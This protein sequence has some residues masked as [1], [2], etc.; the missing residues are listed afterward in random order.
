M[1]FSRTNPVTHETVDRAARLDNDKVSVAASGGQN[2]T[3][4]PQRNST[5]AGNSS[6][7]G[8]SKRFTRDGRGRPNVHQQNGYRKPAAPL[9]AEH[10]QTTS[11]E[12]PVSDAAGTTQQNSVGDSQ[13]SSSEIP[14]S[15]QDAPLPKRNHQRRSYAKDEPPPS[16]AA[17]PA[18]TIESTE[19]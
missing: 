18:P 12:Q 19:T 4:T 17:K 5:S 9:A 7:G 11:N 1:F 3:S 14:S 2:G 16:S 8:Q 10:P 6:R 13:P 15:R